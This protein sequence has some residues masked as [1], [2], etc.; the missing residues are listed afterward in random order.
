M[1]AF[2]GLEQKAKSTGIVT[3]ETENAKAS[4]VQ[5]LKMKLSP[6]Y[7]APESKGTEI[8]GPGARVVKEYD[9]IRRQL[10]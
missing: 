5:E 2:I 10:G 6:T 7:F 4:P 8:I 9:R 3:T 1:A